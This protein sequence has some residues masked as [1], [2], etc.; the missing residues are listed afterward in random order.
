MAGLINPG[1]GSSTNRQT[2]L[3]ALSDLTRY[4]KRFLSEYQTVSSSPSLPSGAASEAKQDTAIALL[5]K[6]ETQL[7]K[8]TWITIPTN[9]VAYNYYAGVAAGNPSGN[10]NNIETAVFSDAGGIVFTQTF[11]YDANDNVLSIV[12]S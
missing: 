2:S 4:L 10:T 9:S 8:D 6:I 1:K 12:V 5:Q 11:T 7:N 3:E